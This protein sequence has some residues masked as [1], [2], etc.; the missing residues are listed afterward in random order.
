MPDYHILCS[1]NTKYNF[2]G[3]ANPGHLSLGSAGSEHFP[4]WSL[5]GAWSSALR[6]C[7]GPVRPGTAAFPMA[8]PQHNEFKI[9]IVIKIHWN[10]FLEYLHVCSFMSEGPFSPKNCCDF[11][12]RPGSV[13]WSLLKNLGAAL[14][15]IILPVF[16][17]R[18]Q[19]SWQKEARRAD[20]NSAVLT[21]AWS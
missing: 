12:R 19:M 21:V 6:H 18:I 13:L 16:D 10:E 7:G 5:Q 8:S 1:G 17:L 14:V 3:S 15:R 11:L 2:Q 20:G 4:G 9:L